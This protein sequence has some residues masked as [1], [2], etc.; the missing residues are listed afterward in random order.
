MP[1]ELGGRAPDFELP[2]TDGERYR[3]ASGSPPATLG[4]W[5]CN[6]CPYA[7]AW[8]TGMLG[9]AR[10][11]ADRGVRTLAINSNDG[12]KYPADAFDAMVER[13]QQDGGWPHP[14]LHDANQEVASA[15]GAERTPQLFVLDPQLRL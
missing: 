5:A 1:I 6:H 14:Y 4:Y 12:E 3:L 8:H 13:V 10:E 11:Y 9:V 15:W 2:A 7:I